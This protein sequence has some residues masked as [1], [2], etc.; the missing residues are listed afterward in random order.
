VRPSDWYF[1]DGQAVM[2][3]QIKQFRIEAKSLNRLLLKNDPALL[4]PERLKP[5]LRVDE[6]QP[7][8]RSHNSVE[9]DPGE[10][11]KCGLVY[12]D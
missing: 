7:Q 9:D 3:R 4:A 12:L 5:T 8:Y 10:L 11:S 6:W 1:L 2:P